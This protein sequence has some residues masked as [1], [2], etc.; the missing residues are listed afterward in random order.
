MKLS[1][2]EF[3]WDETNKKYY[4]YLWKINSFKDLKFAIKKETLK[5]YEK[6]LCKKHNGID[7]H[8][9]SFH[10]VI[11]ENEIDCFN[12]L[13]DLTKIALFIKSENINN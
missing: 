8:M 1:I 4:Y 3:I 10:N 2:N 13:K 9:K 7:E 12:Y 5:N 11:F 6:K